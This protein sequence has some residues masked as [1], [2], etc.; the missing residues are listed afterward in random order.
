MVAAM[1]PLVIAEAGPAIA[2]RMKLDCSDFSTV[3]HRHG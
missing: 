3:I 2:T 1:V